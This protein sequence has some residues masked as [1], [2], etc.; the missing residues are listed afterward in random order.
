MLSGTGLAPRLEFTSASA[1]D[2]LA[3]LL[4]EISDSGTQKKLVLFRRTPGGRLSAEAPLV[5]GEAACAMLSGVA[6]INRTEKGWR[7]RYRTFAS[8]A[9]VLEGPEVEG[10]SEGAVVCGRERVFLIAGK[11][12]ITHA[13]MW[14]PGTKEIS[15]PLSIRRP[16]DATNE[17]D[18]AV[19]TD[20]AAL[21][22]VR[23]SD[24]AAISVFTWSGSEAPP[25]WTRAQ[26]HTTG[27]IAL[28]VVEALGDAIGLA[29]S[30]SVDGKGSCAEGKDASDTALRVGVL[31]RDGHVLHPLDRVE[32][33]RCGAEAGPFWGGWANRRFHVMWPRPADAACARAGV[34]Y[35]G[36][37]YV[38]LDGSRSKEPMH[39][40]R[41][42]LPAEAVAGAGC[43]EDRCYV[44]SITRG[45]SPCAPGD[46][47]EAGAI[48]VTALR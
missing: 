19:T 44:A 5:A 41:A 29:V 4:G 2:A 8:P 26:F 14:N 24:T 46:N 9:A 1:H 7:A 20:G 25:P 34:R 22:I 33:W 43:D 45:A 27:E 15:T 42:G 18:V 48:E 31:A 10:R 35:G 36:I 38:V 21:V 32:N 30:E 39:V 23:M 37:G 11:D 47:P 6:T 17:D 28:E 40:E 3:L 16:E 13:V 12:E